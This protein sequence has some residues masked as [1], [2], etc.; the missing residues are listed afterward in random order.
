M[1][2]SVLN[3]RYSERDGGA[4]VEDFPLRPD[5]A[6]KGSLSEGPEG[7]TFGPFYNIRRTSATVQ[8]C[9]VTQGETSG[10]HWDVVDVVND[11]AVEWDKEETTCH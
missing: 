6:A 10:R 11:R 2:G 9:A 4:P 7:S 3:V 1:L 5:I 8:H